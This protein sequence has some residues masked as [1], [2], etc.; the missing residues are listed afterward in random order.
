MIDT[1]VAFLLLF[2]SFFTLVAALGIVRLPDVYMRMH[3]ITKASSLATILFLIALIIAHP[4]WRVAF[5]S[6]LLIAFVIATAP[7][8]THALARI[9]VQLGIKMTKG[10]VRNDMKTNDSL[11]KDGTEQ[12]SEKTKAE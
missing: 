3:A 10:M 9:S 1:I 11:E 5:G 12:A 4:S 8:S 2:A 6:L 7:I